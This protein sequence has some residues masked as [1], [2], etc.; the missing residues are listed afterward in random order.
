MVMRGREVG[1]KHKPQLVC[2]S[3]RLPGQC[4]VLTEASRVTTWS[5]ARA[6]EWCGVV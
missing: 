4:P 2:S 5:P 6:N 1:T 3:D